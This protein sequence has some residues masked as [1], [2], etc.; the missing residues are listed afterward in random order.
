MATLTV[1]SLP[2]ATI[3]AQRHSTAAVAKMT[4][5]REILAV[6]PDIAVLSSK[7]LLLTK[8]NY[9]VTPA[10]SERELFT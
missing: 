4:P 5:W 10:T 8:A 7:S 9:R 6:E 1:P 3:P 2:S